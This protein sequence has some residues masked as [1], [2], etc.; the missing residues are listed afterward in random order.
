[1]HASA[2]QYTTLSLCTVRHT[3]KNTQAE[4]VATQQLHVD[5]TPNSKAERELGSPLPDRHTTLMYNSNF[6]CFDIYVVQ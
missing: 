1:M 5:G 6:Y 3:R 4:T 2:V